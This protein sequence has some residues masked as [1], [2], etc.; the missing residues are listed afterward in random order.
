M[1]ILLDRIEEIDNPGGSSSVLTSRINEL[2]REEPSSLSSRIESLDKEEEEPSLLGRVGRGIKNIPSAAVGLLKNV[3]K[4]ALT[5]PEDGFFKFKPERLLDVGRGVASG[6]SFGI[7]P[8][9]KAETE[10][11]AA[12]Q[13][14]GNLLGFLA[15]FK[16]A[17]KGANIGL[18][19]LGFGAKTASRA[20]P[21]IAGGVAGGAE[22]ASRGEFGEAV[23][24][25]TTGAGLVGALELLG[26]AR[27]SKFKERASIRKAKK[28]QL[29]TIE[30]TPKDPVQEVRDLLKEAEEIPKPGQITVKTTERSQGADF[31]S[32]E[33]NARKAFFFEL[34]EASNKINPLGREVEV[35]EAP[36]GP[37]RVRVAIDP[38]SGKLTVQTVGKGADASL[39]RF[40][41]QLEALKGD[42]KRELESVTTRRADQQ[43][44]AGRG[45]GET[46][47][48]LNQTEPIRD[49]IDPLQ[50]TA[51][52]A[53]D[54]LVKASKTIENLNAQAKVAATVNPD[55]LKAKG[56]IKPEAQKKAFQKAEERPSPESTFEFKFSEKDVTEAQVTFEAAIRKTQ[57]ALEQLRAQG[58]L[59]T[60]NIGRDLINQLNLASKNF[61]KHQ[62][63]AS[64]GLSRFNKPIPAD[65][66]ETMKELG[67]EMKGLKSIRQRLP[68]Y[69]SI[70]AQIKALRDPNISPKLKQQA[71]GQ[72]GRDLVDSFRLN[73]FSITSF[74]LDLVGNAAELGAQAAEGLGR[75]LV[76]V[77]KGNPTFPSMQATFRA[78]RARGKNNTAKLTKEITNELGFTALGEPIRGGFKAGP[79]TFTERSTTASKGLD[80]LVGTPLYLKGFIDTGAKR[81][82][83]TMNLMEDALLKAREKGLTGLDKQ[84]FIT[85]FFKKPPTQALNKAV[86]EGK[87]AG[88]S[89]NLDSIVERA[90]LRQGAITPLLI[91]AFARWPFQFTRWAAEM[92]GYNRPML[93]K[94]RAGTASA[95]EIGGYLV[96]TA[97]GVG[98]LMLI[99]KM[100]YDQIDWNTLEYK[101][102]NGDRT[103]LQGREPIASALVLLAVLKGDL[104]AFSGAVGRSSF[105]FANLI[106]GEF[107]LVGS[108]VNALSDANRGGYQNPRTF[109][110]EV[111]STL[112]RAIPGQALLAVTKEIFDS[113]V[114]EGIGAKLPLISKA[115]P[116]RID[117]STGKALQ[118]KQK[119][120]GTDIEIPAISGVPVPGFRRVFNDIQRIEALVGLRVSRPRRV[121]IGGFPPTDVPEELRQ[122]F[123][124][125]FGKQRQRI[126]GGFA[127]R[128]SNQLDRNP[129]LGD[130]ERWLSQV[131]KKIQAFDS[132]A[133]KIAKTV[134]NR[135]LGTSGKVPRKLSIRERRAGRK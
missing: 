128:I 1:G 46:P 123:L 86:I 72:L 61:R 55:V 7:I 62:A 122:D 5:P 120:P 54:N 10:A 36:V 40:E 132:R 79:G 80:Y 8:K 112:N 24:G 23:E 43:A 124:R 19:T 38:A 42:L 89:R 48:E 118:L 32:A 51:K 68:L 13:E 96:K 14:A 126:S 75:D 109:K 44:K 12:R 73:L 105:P 30:K 15:P 130:N 133:A 131:R 99:D 47:P 107:G 129:D 34:N 45:P 22:P 93:A 101:H 116:E 121:S 81:F 69:T 113:K 37:K 71:R 67:I 57:G 70:R 21:V 59:T 90:V 26:L 76:R 110:N 25:A 94:I 63:A 100:L 83:V 41:P 92:V 18:K 50:V 85:E 134:V 119:I 114:R 91:N 58:D 106:E 27:P 31:T 56:T 88:F 35:S 2:D 11:Q 103:A 127:S 95:E 97:T 64:R 98:G 28:D 78:I 111:V 49:Q 74:S 117:P 108:L 66:L 77:V 9:S 87:K 20:A 135:R 16:L 53:G 17:S 3:G 60:S 102:A 4:A 33:Q 29:V 115:L 52:N 125:E 82:S 84:N 104:P 6:L 39:K 65:V